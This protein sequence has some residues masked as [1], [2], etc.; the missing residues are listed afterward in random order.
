MASKTPIAY[1]LRPNSF[2]EIIGQEHLIGPKSTLRKNIENGNITSMILYGPPGT[3]KTTIA[4]VIAKSTKSEFRTVNAVASGIKDLRHVIQRAQT[5]KEQLL[6]QQ[7]ILFIDEIHRFNKKQQD[8]LLPFVENG[9]VTLIGATTENP[10]FEVN[11]A[12]LSRCHVYLL[13]NLSAA[14]IKVILTQAIEKLEKSLNI[15]I[16]ISPKLITEIAHTANS[17]ARFALNTLE[18]IT[19]E[20]LRGTKITDKTI[21]SIMQ[22]KALLYDKNGEEHYNIISALHKSMRDSDPDAAAY[23][24]MR[25]L[26]GGEDPKYIVRRM[27]RFASEDIGNK[28]SNALKI[29]IA[30][31]ES[32]IFLGVPECNTALIQC[33]QYLANAPKSNEC[34]KALGLIKNDIDTYGPLP[35]PL[36]LR[37]A[38]TKLDKSFGYGEGYKYAHNYKDAKVDQEHFPKELKNRKYFAKEN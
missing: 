33:A 32:V 30:T 7:T 18:Q 34:Y 6:Q 36:H 2:D 21:K 19:Y 20:I 12:L 23:W 35:V 17:D 4:S 28:D 16:D 9:T 27:I 38:T 13:N 31:K 15:D 14:H 37:N 24:T 5:Q 25:M 26:M 29:A 22:K 10:S 3:G 11:S 8:Y 1:T